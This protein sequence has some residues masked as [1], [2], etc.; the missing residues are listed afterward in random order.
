MYCIW[1]FYF[2]RK[3]TDEE[4]VDLLSE[5]GFGS[6]DSFYRVAQAISETLP[7][8]KPRKEANRR[9]PGWKRAIKF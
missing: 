8:R 1:H 3:A 2:G 7:Q 5:T 9:F 4:L 6:K